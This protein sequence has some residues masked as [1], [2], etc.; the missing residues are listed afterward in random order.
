[1]QAKLRETV[2]V[3][4]FGA[5]GNGVADDTAAIQAA[6]TATSIGGNL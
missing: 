6:V 3:K 1:V 5:V 2:S 4:D